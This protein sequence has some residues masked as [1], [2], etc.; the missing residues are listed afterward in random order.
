MPP[1]PSTP[2]TQQ[3]WDPLYSASLIASK[4]RQASSKIQANASGL[5]RYKTEKPRHQLI[6]A[7]GKEAAGKGTLVGIW[8]PTSSPSCQPLEASRRLGKQE[9]TRLRLSLRFPIP[10]LVP[11]SESSEGPHTTPVPKHN[12]S[13]DTS[14]GTKG[15]PE[16]L[17][18]KP[19]TVQAW[20]LP[21]A[22]RQSCC[23]RGPQM[24]LRDLAQKGFLSPGPPTCYH[25]PSHFWATWAYLSIP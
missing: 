4:R 17:P 16:P 3:L 11:V 22:G 21:Q 24:A 14:W 23:I 18:A 8:C 1:A 5:N 6:Q 13:Q 19:Q 9:H 10:S 15:I 7:R 20:S 25:T 2:Q 12:T